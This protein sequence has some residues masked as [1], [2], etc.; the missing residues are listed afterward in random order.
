M[1]L[2]FQFTFSNECQAVQLRNGSV[3]MNSRGVGTLRL[4]TI[5]DDGGERSIPIF[6]F[7]FVFSNFDYCHSWGETVQA[8]DLIEPFDG[9]EGLKRK[10]ERKRGRNNNFFGSKD[11]RCETKTLE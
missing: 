6:V 1:V 10:G 5:S 9:C 11:L 3:L 8:P 7:P 2:S 4:L